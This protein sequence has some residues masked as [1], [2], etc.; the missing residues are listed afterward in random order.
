M[1]REPAVAGSFYPGT[2]SALTKTLKRLIHPVENPKK[3]ICAIAPH[4]GY[5][6]SGE[7]AGRIFSE[8]SVP[9]KCIV[10]SPNHRGYGARA[11]IMAKGSWAIPT[12]EIPVDE[13]ISSSL[14]RESTGLRDDM[15]AHL[16]E[17]SLEVQLPFLLARQP[18]LRIAPIT[19]S[20]LGAAGC[21]E[22]A[23]AIA[24]VVSKCD[25]D[26]LIVCSTDMNH[27]DAQAETMEKDRMAIEKVLDLDASGLVE[28]CSS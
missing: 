21:A 7:V 15:S 11:A 20:L 19:I 2:F 6:Y 12:G 1:K 25:E 26:I 5:V 24:R 9:E 16:Q 18:K 13:D 4:A 17:H 14:L 8:I 22:L 3:V 28:I 10:L 23:S 27:F